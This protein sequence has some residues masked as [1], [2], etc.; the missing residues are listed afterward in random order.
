M[1]VDAYDKYR[2]KKT[3]DG[4]GGS[5]IVLGVATTIWGTMV[6]HDSETL[7]IVDIREDVKIGDIIEVQES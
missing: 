5:H 6:V 1:A 2:P 7:L 4:R 3:S